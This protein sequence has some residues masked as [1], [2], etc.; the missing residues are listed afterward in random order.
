MGAAIFNFV[1]DHH[2]QQDGVCEAEAARV[3]NMVER[4]KSAVE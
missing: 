3:D 4:I 2:H 1:G